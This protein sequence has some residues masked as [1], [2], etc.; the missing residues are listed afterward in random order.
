M[1]VGKPNTMFQAQINSAEGHLTIIRTHY[2]MRDRDPSTLLL[3]PN[4]HAPLRLSAEGL[5]LCSS[6]QGD[7]IAHYEGVAV[8]FGGKIA[9]GIIPYL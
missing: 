9:K 8:H 1:S 6:A 7:G 2:R 5:S 3:L 4:R